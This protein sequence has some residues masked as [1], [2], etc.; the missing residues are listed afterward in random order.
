M[1]MSPDKSMVMSGSA[2]GRLRLWNIKKGSVVGYAWERHHSP[3]RYI[4]QSPN[5][6]EIEGHDCGVMSLCWFKDGI[7]IFSA[8]NDDTIR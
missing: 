8:S 7:H 3:V 5:A 1:A 4:D 2:D 6:Q